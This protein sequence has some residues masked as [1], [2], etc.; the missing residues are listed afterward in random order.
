[1][2]AGFLLPED[3]PGKKL[4]GRVMEV[5]SYTLSAAPATTQNSGRYNWV[6]PPRRQGFLSGVIVSPPPAWGAG[7]CSV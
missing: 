5:S 7:V 3:R 2:E 1:M 4:P 6:A